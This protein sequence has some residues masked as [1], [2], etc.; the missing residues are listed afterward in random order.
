LFE[1]CFSA[2]RPLGEESESYYGC[3]VDAAVATLC[4]RMA[5]GDRDAVEEALGFLERDQFF[6]RSG[7]ARERLA[8][9]L[10]QMGLTAAQKSRA[11][12][13]VLTTVDGERHCPHPGVGRL[14]RAVADNELRRQLRVRLH[15]RDA[16]LAGRA[17]RM[18]VNVRHPGLSPADIS[19]ARALVLADAARGQWL[20]PAVARLATYIW[21]NAWEAELRSLLPYHGP[22]RAAAKRL[23]SRVDRRRERRPGP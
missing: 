20:S 7:Y 4:D 23:L 21:S 13:V 3:R 22:D 8:R 19:A 18:I 10:A 14:A 15:D 9:R 16:A 5:D 1:A 12:T 17:L 11:R 6:F 2:V